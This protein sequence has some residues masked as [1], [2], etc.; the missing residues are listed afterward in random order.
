MIGALDIG[1]TKIAAG[2]VDRRG[3]VLARAVEPT[4]P[5]LGF[6]NALERMSRLLAGC[7][8][9]AG[10]R[11]EGIGIGCTGPVDPVTGSIGKAELLHEWIGAPLAPKLAERFQA[12][13]AMENDADAAA[14]AEYKWGA[15]RG[16]QVFVYV[17]VGTGIGVGMVVR[18]A[19]YRGADGA[20][21]ELGHSILD[22]SGGPLCYCGLSGCWEALASGPAIE[23]WYAS[24]PGGSALRATEICLRAAQQGEALAVQAVE[25]EAMYLGLGLVNMVTAWCPDAVALGGGVIQGSPLF[26]ETPRDMVHRLVTQVPVDKTRVEAAA[27]GNEAGLKGAACAW[28]HRYRAAEMAASEG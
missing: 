20:H 12:P 3:N 26:V 10:G 2:V 14:L 5:E 16:A 24:Q 4:S 6:E 19:V 8:A 25:R 27:L 22:F 11:I 7:A 23:K 18:G 17:T 21:P 1:G 9:Q 15:G 28:L 13:A